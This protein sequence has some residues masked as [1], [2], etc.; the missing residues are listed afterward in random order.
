MIIIKLMLT[1]ILTLTAVLIEHKL[2]AKVGYSQLA[3]MEQT[4]A[5]D[6]DSEQLVPS[7]Y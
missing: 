7:P 3:L 4:L 5:S 1:L 6:T 2:D